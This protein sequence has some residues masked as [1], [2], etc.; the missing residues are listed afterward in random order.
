[1]VRSRCEFRQ[2]IEKGFRLQASNPS[3]VRHRKMI[4]I[5]R[6]RGKS[7]PLQN[8]RRQGTGVKRGLLA[9]ANQS[10]A[11]STPHLPRSYD[12]RDTVARPPS[13]LRRLHLL[14]ICSPIFCCSL[15][16]LLSLDCLGR[17]GRS[18]LSAFG[19][20]QFSDAI[21]VSLYA[22]ALVPYPGVG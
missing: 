16:S 8:G 4:V 3:T 13:G 21:V 15:L 1:V 6:R 20:D 9:L 7:W 19:G 18:F 14:N 11:C 17:C 12:C 5:G 22:C 10:S 2:T